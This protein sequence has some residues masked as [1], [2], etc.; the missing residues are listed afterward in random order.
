MDENVV[1]ARIIIL[2]LYIFHYKLEIIVYNLI[3]VEQDLKGF[4]ASLINL[5]R[6]SSGDFNNKVT[7]SD[8][9]LGYCI[10]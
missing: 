10:M 7:E 4:D 6:W 5:F 2:T 9:L 1:Y 3:L 8:S